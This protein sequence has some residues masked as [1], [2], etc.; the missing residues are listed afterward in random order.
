M[1]KSRSR[2][3][4][5]LAGGMSTT[6]RVAE[7][8]LPADTAVDANLNSFIGVF[9]LPTSDGTA[10]QI[11]ETDGSGAL[12]FTDAASG[13]GESI[14]TLKQAGDVAVHTGTVRWYAPR[15]I[16][17]TDVIMRVDTAPTGST[18]NITINRVG[19]QAGTT[20]MSMATGA[21]KATSTTDF[22]LDADDY[23]TVDVTQVGSTVAGEDLK[24]TFR[25][26]DQ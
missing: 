9:T 14:V 19:T 2:L 5:E 7:A 1:A 25:Y 24:V 26:V 13:G 3:F 22:D 16:T 4:A 11:L 18:L 15:D 10:G 23:M 12:T 20:S 17:I 21:T 8:N 6:G